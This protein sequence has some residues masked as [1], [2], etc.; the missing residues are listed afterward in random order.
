LS[1]QAESLDRSPYFTVVVMKN[2]VDAL[3][4]AVSVCSCQNSRVSD[5]ILDEAALTLKPSDIYFDT[6]AKLLAFVVDPYSKIDISERVGSLIY[7][8]QIV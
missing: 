5:S 7:G 3:E 2:R 8:L 4:G 6:K 1:T